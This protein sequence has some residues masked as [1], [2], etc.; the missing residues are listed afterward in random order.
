MTRPGEAALQVL[1]YWAAQVIGRASEEIPDLALLER[2][3]ADE[4]KL[5]AWQ[6]EA[7]LPTIFSQIKREYQSFLPQA[8]LRVD[9]EEIFPHP[10]RGAGNYVNRKAAIATMFDAPQAD[11]AAML[12]HLL[13]ALET[14]AWCLSSPL[15]GIPLYD[16]AR[17]HAALAAAHTAGEQLTLVGGD[18]SGVQDF[19]Y[20][21][22]A[23]GAAKQLRGRSLYLQLLS[24]VIARYIIDKAGMPEVCLLYCGG[25]RFYAL[26][27]D[28][29]AFDLEQLRQEIATVLLVR[30]GIAPFLALGWQQLDDDYAELWK[31]L[32]ETINE[33][34]Q[35]KFATLDA[36]VMRTL[37][38]TP[39]EAELPD[40]ANDTTG[41][42]FADSIKELSTSLADAL[43]L[44]EWPG[45]KRPIRTAERESEDW[46]E[47]LLDLSLGLRML[48]QPTQHGPPTRLRAMRD[49]SA[50]ERTAA[51]SALGQ[52][53]T[54]GRRYTVNVVAKV[55][56]G[57]TDSFEP[58]QSDIDE[59]TVAPNSGATNDPARGMP[60]KGEPMPFSLLAHLSIGIKRWGVLR[61][62]IDDLGQLFGRDRMEGQL[63]ADLAETA[64]LSA[65]LSRFFEGRV[66]A[67]CREINADPARRGALYTVYSGGDDLFI[68]GSWHLL[69]KLAERIRREFNRYVTGVEGMQS[70][71][72]L[73]AGI[74]LHTRKFPIY[75]AADMAHEALEAA[76]AFT[77]NDGTKK[78]AL[79]FLGRTI[80]WEQ[81]EEVATLQQE[82]VQLVEQGAPRAL[83]ITLQSLAT[84]AALTRFT[85]DGRLQ[86]GHG[87][88]LWQGAYT[89]TRL[90][91]RSKEE[92]RPFIHT[93]G[94]NMRER[95]ADGYIVRAGM[96]ARWAQLLLRGADV[97]NEGQ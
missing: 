79:T 20:D 18:V 36:S 25:G 59:D 77:R 57:D 87:P 24:E 3:G 65:A 28:T 40:P 88:W 34:K 84:K 85:K 5:R 17:V 60:K 66:G 90:A 62:D 41:N 93:L 13:D 94:K 16:F 47:T 10:E 76:K 92:Q 46:Y 70:P 69:P 75:Q 27:P 68:V 2:L 30:H 61:M 72:T 12:T 52:R 31:T 45:R 96:A 43:Y 33:Q 91:E 95:I 11:Q 49:L 83:L 39:R 73:S 86:Y 4:Q 9:S 14:E 23:G 37:L 58:D 19:I 22:P 35:R 81:Y 53:G 64:A 51:L 54:L 67:I 82:L 32:H 55:L 80:G 1:R 97:A 74:T 89:L 29:A 7:A 48:D 15:A 71:I 8:A 42:A 26:L 63:F 50:E 21:I 38:F 6:P 44:R 56:E 78:D